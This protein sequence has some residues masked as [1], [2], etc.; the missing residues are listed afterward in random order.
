MLIGSL[1]S[2]IGGLELG[3]EW[4]GLGETIWQVEREPYCRAILAKHWPNAT[5]FD[6]VCT[7]GAATLPPV[8]FICGGFPC[9]D[10]SS[11]GNRAGLA[12]ERSGL[13]REYARI[14]DE[15]RPEWVVVENV[16]SGANAWVDAVV[17]DL[18][19]FGYASLPL[20]I[21]AS[22]LG[23]P[24]RRARVFIVAHAD[25][26][27]PGGVAESARHL[28]DADTDANGKSSRSVDAEVAEPSELA[29]NPY[30]NAIRIESRWSGGTRRPGATEPDWSGGGFAEPNMVRALHG[31]P[32]RLDGST[33]RI[34]ALGNSVVPQQAEV[35]GHVVLELRRRMVRTA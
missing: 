5:R 33:A 13:W 32:R 7:V 10:V 8:D 35:V 1:F 15:L 6:D 25:G 2:G 22:D 21:S 23:A 28:V 11:A 18:A 29:A 14:V 19:E 4:S 30:G 31:I 12:G 24:H 34:S 20:P 16:A 9:Q 17:R 26:V 27:T 3:L